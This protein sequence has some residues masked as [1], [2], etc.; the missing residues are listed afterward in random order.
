MTYS[1]I[2]G[3]E[4]FY[5]KGGEIGVLI[6]HG[7]MGTPQSVRYLGERFA[8]LGYTVLAVRLEGHGTDYR[9]LEKRSHEEWFQ[10]LE[11]GY[12]ELKKHCSKVFVVGQSM[13][14]ALSL[15]LAYKYPEIDGVLTIN[16]ALR[17]PAYEYL[18]QL[19]QPPRYIDE[20]KPDIKNPN[21]HEI[22]Y[23][24]APVS[25][26]FELQKVMASIPSLLSSI[27]SPVLGIYSVDDHVVP[28]EST[29][30]IIKHIR[31]SIKEKLVLENSY[32]VASMD[33][34]QEKIVEAGHEFIQQFNVRKC[35]NL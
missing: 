10:S 6:C 3:A 29:E 27:H 1:V 18:Q 21:V 30:Y 23:E 9:D 32:H 35:A 31:S 5:I 17:V 19:K 12:K 28:P 34:D 20:G 8:Q 7:F 15:K 16:A 24:K 33:Y 13:G 11:Q 25:A 14:G 22:T 26:I 2:H 4:A